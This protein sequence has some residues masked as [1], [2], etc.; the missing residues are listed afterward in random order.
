MF[1]VNHSS[2]IYL[3]YTDYKFL[4]GSSEIFR[5]HVTHQKIIGQIFAVEEAYTM[6]LLKERFFPDLS[7]SDD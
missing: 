4:N 3:V 2:F 7:P 6:C 5:K 1:T